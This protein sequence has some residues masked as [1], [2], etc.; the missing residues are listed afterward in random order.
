MCPLVWME[1]GSHPALMIQVNVHSSMDVCMCCVC[2][3]SR[4]WRKLLRGA[5]T[6]TTSTNSSLFSQSALLAVLGQVI[7]IT[8]IEKPNSV[9]VLGFLWRICEGLPYWVARS[10][11]RFTVV[12]RELEQARE[13]LVSTL[14]SKEVELQI[15]RKV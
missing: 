7:I 3:E 2:V 4:E 6:L 9:I 10:E 5:L 1:N 12:E 14:R 13:L 8:R 15:C 11:H